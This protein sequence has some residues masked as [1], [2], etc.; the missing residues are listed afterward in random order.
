MKIKLIDLK[1]RARFEREKT[2]YGIKMMMVSMR[3][4]NIEITSER[5]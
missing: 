1:E 3:E 4:M 5:L 2:N